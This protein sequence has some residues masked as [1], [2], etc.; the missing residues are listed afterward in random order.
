MF[1]LF[2]E[3]MIWNCKADAH[4]NLHVRLHPLRLATESDK[5]PSKS[6]HPLNMIIISAASEI[7]VHRPRP[8][9]LFCNNICCI[10]HNFE[11]LKK[12][13]TVGSWTVARL[14]V[15]TY[16]SYS[17]QTCCIR[18]YIIIYMRNGMVDAS[19]RLNYA[20]DGG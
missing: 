11:T 1:V 14:Y 18:I 5:F 9:L 8:L 10:F 13:E 12:T 3:Q 17:P 16:I 15:H 4:F 6:G 2:H 19:F 7:Q 20:S